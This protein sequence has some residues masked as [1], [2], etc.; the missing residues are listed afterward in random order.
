[1]SDTQFPSAPI[2]DFNEPLPPRPPRSG[3]GF[4]VA[5]LIV[6]I[7]ALVFAFVPFVSY[8]AIGAGV[9][10]VILGIVGLIAKHRPRGTAIA[11]LTIGTIG[12]ILAIMM[13]ILYA[14]IFFGISKAVSDQHTAAATTHTVVYSITGAAQDAD[15]TYSTYSGGNFGSEQSSSTPLPFSKTL[16]VKGSSGSFSFHSFTLSAI[17]G[18]DDTGSIACSITVDGKTVASQT[19]TGSLAAVTCSGTN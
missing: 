14:A 12:L 15:V 2:Q 17:N 13:T 5:A 8:L 1:M 6:G 16:T 10:A 11:G 3:N 4:G 19:S 18:I 9:I 7:F